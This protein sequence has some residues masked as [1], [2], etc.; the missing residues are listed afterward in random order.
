[1]LSPWCAPEPLVYFKETMITKNK[2]IKHITAFVTIIGILACLVF[3]FLAYESMK[4]ATP[5]HPIASGVGSDSAD[6]MN[7]AS[8]ETS[9]TVDAVNIH[10][11]AADEPRML[12]IKS[13]NISARIKPMGINSIG[14]IAAPVNIYDSGW[15]TGSA[16]PGALG[17]TFI[18]GHASGAT[19]QGLFAYL[20]TLKNGNEVSIERG[21]RKVLMYKVVHVETVLKDSINMMKVLRTYD[22]AR[23]GLNLMTCTGN[24][25]K[26][27]QTYDKRVIVYTER[28]S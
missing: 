26:N 10:Q 25:I 27:E 24:W 16:K 1:L 14:A 13:L 6:V 19:R 9:V 5:T 18:D 4:E 17:A 22:G 7:E 8:D 28:V 20:E 11:V 3:G 12:N 15:Y 23:E 21:D 2:Q